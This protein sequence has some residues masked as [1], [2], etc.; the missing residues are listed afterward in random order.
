MY[1]GIVLGLDMLADQRAIDP[2]GKYMLVVLTDGETNEGLGFD[3]VDEA[4]AGA[5][6]PV[7]T[8]GFE[9][10]LDELGRLAS[11]VE[12]ASINASE[13]DVEFKLVS[14]FNAGV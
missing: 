4:I 1:D 6:I 11:L 8:V 7:F 12:A 13:G 3:N 14:L 10:D 2:G 9:A 5:R